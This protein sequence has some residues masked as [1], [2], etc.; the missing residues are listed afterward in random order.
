MLFLCRWETLS[1]FE[2]LQVGSSLLKSKVTLINSLQPWIFTHIKVLQ[3]ASPEAASKDRDK[4][5][6]LTGMIWSTCSSL[7]STPTD[8][9]MALH[10][11]LVSL[12]ATLDDGLE[13]IVQLLARKTLNPSESGSPIVSPEPTEPTGE[14]EEFQEWA[15][16][17][18]LSSE[19]HHRASAAHMLLRLT[20]HLIKHLINTLVKPDNSTRLKTLDTEGIYAK[21]NRLGAGNDDLA[22]SLWGPQEI[23]D[24]NDAA[25]SLT[26]SAVDLTQT[27]LEQYDEGEAK[28]LAERI[29]SVN[30]Q[31]STSESPAVKND[32]I[33]WYKTCLN[34]IRKARDSIVED[35]RV[36][37]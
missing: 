16:D 35:S 30:L 21:A 4:A 7:T 33:R 36:V 29:S 25:R 6:T 9:R 31:P 1:L 13:E 2:S 22:S 34:Q 12:L 5:L 14:E 8:E 23:G 24:I 18:Q 37:D 10:S 11:A 32:D 28:L 15:E 26:D 3:S 19:E 20:R 27:I 17:D